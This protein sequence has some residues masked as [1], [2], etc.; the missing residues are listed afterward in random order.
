MRPPQSVEQRGL[1]AEVLDVDVQADAAEPTPGEVSERVMKSHAVAPAGVDHRVREHQLAAPLADIEL[2]HVDPDPERRV[3]RRQRVPRRKRAG[4]PMPDP[5]TVVPAHPAERVPGLAG[6]G[7][8]AAIGCWT[9]WR[10][11]EQAH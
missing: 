2:N 8:H 10:D 6:R 9:S 3:K 1:T 4:T 5:L 7:T 11:G